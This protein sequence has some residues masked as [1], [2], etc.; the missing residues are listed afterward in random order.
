M[1]LDPQVRAF[2]DYLIALNGPLLHTL[3]PEAGREVVAAM[4]PM[5]DDPQPVAS[6]ENRRIAGP[7]GEIPLRVYTPEG[8][9]PF[10]VLV[11]FHGG[12]WVIGDLE[13]HDDMC[14][15]LTNGAGCVVVSVDYRLAPEH[16]FPAAVEDAYA[17]TKWVAE[18][19][20][21]INGD[22]GRLAIGG[23]SAGG[24]LT[25]VVTQLARDQK[26]P[27]LIF[28]LLIYPAMDFTATEMVSRL[29]YS[30]G[31]ALITEDMDW[32]TDHYLN[33]REDYLNPLASP[34]LIK[35][36]EDLP[37]ALIIT[38]EYDPLRDEGE[39]Y[40][41]KLQE[42]GVSVT[43]SRYDGLIHGFFRMPKVMDKAL[44]AVAEASQALRDAFSSQ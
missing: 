10:P 2:L 4:T 28:Q 5:L 6:V 7:A 9:G 11:Y 19:A 33:S 26:G 37:P 44:E 41:H 25:A 35:S 3:S 29:E 18:H 22:A 21:E 16:K 24:N 40:G 34:M 27:H 39:E 12:G 30:Q 20:G 14:R 43:I 15:R 31:Y 36:F 17:A 32:F 8:K 42:A 23:D 1:P 38:A 13:T